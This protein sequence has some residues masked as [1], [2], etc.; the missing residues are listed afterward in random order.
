MWTPRIAGV[1]TGVDHI[2]ET[3]NAMYGH[4]GLCLTRSYGYETLSRRLQLTK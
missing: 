2:S 3:L 4:R 1:D